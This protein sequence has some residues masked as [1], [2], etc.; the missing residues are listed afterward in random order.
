[1]REQRPDT[2]GA[3]GGSKMP[4]WRKIVTDAEKGPSTLS[5]HSAPRANPPGCG[6][7]APSVALRPRAAPCGRHARPHA[8]HAL[9]LIPPRG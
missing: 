8:T 6:L 4:S 7:T 2:Q 9:N 1:M 5:S 3:K